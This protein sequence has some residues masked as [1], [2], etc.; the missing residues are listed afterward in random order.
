MEAAHFESILDQICRELTIKA[1]TPGRFTDS[2]QFERAVREALVSPMCAHGI[3]VDLSP[4]AQVFP[5]IV[6]GSFG[7]EV[8]FTAND[9]WRC[10]ANSVFEGSRDRNVD[11]LYL[12]YGKMGGQP[13]V[14]WG[15][16]GECVVHVRTSHVPRFE[17]EIG[18][19]QSLFQRMGI[20]YE[21]FASNSLD[22][23][24][25]LIRNYA[26]GRLRPGEQLWWLD[27]AEDPVHSLPIQARLYMSLDQE[28]KRR[29]RA[30]ASLLCPE[31][32]RPSRS[33]KKYDRAALYLLTYRGVLCSQAR[34]L[35]SAGSV[36]NRGTS[37]RGGNYVLKALQDI[38]DEMREAAAR[39]PDELFAIYWGQSCPPEDRLTAWL[40]KAD[41]E[42][43]GWVPSEDLFRPHP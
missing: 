31:V 34:D 13:E 36:A 6:L 39:L 30:E 27:S 22:E 8:K 9:T 15:R 26:R 43:R 10:I 11:K 18:A 4:Q 32:V 1:Q 24:M 16:Y 14:R 42:A 5:D 41:A 29:L 21:A 19:G 40:S 33:K 3:E 25:V 37:Q 28:E 17:V 23:R 2:K 35:F 7:I 20:T 38:E 12:V